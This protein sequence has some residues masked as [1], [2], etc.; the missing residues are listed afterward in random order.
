MIVVAKTVY[1]GLSDS[2]RTREKELD[3]SDREK[4]KDVISYSLLGLAD[5]PLRL[6][7]VIPVQMS[8]WL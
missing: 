1:D 3:N 5:H 8:G 4:E 7:Q 6:T 2:I